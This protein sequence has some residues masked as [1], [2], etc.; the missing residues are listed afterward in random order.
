MTSKLH[1][2]Y[3]SPTATTRKIV[4]AIAEGFGAPDVERHDLTRQKQGPTLKLTEGVAII[5]VPVY[6]G[7]VPL[8]C[9]ERLAGI[10]ADG[11]PAILVALYGNREFE[12][13]LVELR[14]V[15]SAAGFSI[16][17]AGAFIGEHS[18]S[19]PELPFSPGRPD[20]DDLTKARAFGRDCAAKLAAG[21]DGLTPEIAGNV[22]YRDRVPLGGIAP[23]T[24]M[25]TCT[26]C[27]T[28]AR[29]CPTFVITLSDAEVLTEAAGCV[30][31]CACVKNCPTGARV[32][33]HPV[34]GERRA[35][36][37]KICTTRKE[38]RVFI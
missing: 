35:M 6:A 18:Y 28:C 12:D 13:A 24:V 37:Q 4:T 26:L 9:L 19:T 29:V 15:V 20:A 34:I 17:A 36:L 2:I 7:R 30:M 32:M 1:L 10:S 38:P 25:E 5:G 3:F 31:C 11:C 14:D 33:R 8:V 27:G 21:W 16:L 22:P 23:E